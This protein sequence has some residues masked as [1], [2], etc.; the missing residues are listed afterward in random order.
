[1]LNPLTKREAAL[2]LSLCLLLGWGLVIGQASDSAPAAPTTVELGEA[3]ASVNGALIEREQFDVEFQRL[4][5]FA[6]AADV[7]RLGRGS[8][9]LLDRSRADIAI[10]RGQQS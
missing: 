8:A 3:L 2:C 1:M 6:T 5:A 10:R 7:R 4:A 9:A